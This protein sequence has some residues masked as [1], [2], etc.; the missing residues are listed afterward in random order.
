MQLQAET[1]KDL[2]NKLAQ[3]IEE[4]AIANKRFEVKKFGKTKAAI[5]PISDVFLQKK[6]KVDWAKL[7]GAGIWKDRKDMKN[8]SK[9]VADLRRRE[10]TRAIPKSLYGKSPA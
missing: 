7:P 10:S 1:I 5:V 3:I 8:S 2:R 9:W 6:K 4:V